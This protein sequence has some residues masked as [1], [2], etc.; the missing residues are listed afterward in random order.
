M[1][2]AALVLPVV[3]FLV[4]IPLFALDIFRPVDRLFIT[5][6][7]QAAAFNLYAWGDRRGERC[8]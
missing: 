7:V 5:G 2:K 1:K 8:P 6:L 4:W 3:W